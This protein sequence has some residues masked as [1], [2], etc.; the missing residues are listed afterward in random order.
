VRAVLGDLLRP[1]RG[2]SRAARRA[3]RRRTATASSRSGTWSS[4][5]TSS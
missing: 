4:C 2:H 1:R 3:A 5:S